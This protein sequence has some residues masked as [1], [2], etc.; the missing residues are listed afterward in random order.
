VAVTGGWIVF[1]DESGQRLRPPVARTW[2]PVG[3]TPVIG[4]SGKGS[5]RVSIAGLVCLR[6]GRRGR[7]FYRIRV[8]HGRKHERRSLS[9]ADYA[10]LIT[11][12]VRNS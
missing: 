12:V 10:T 11:A 9:E 6:S 1:E 8:H 5:G 3:Q 2:A 7:L 4:V